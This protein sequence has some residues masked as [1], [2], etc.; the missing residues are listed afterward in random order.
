MYSYDRFPLLTGIALGIVLAPF[1]YMGIYWLAKKLD[2]IG[3][4]PQNANLDDDADWWKK[5]ERKYDDDE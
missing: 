3:Y 2:I 1:F 4:A 5:G